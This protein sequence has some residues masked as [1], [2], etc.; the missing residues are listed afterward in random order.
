MN[1][2]EA[3]RWLVPRVA[4]ALAAGLAAV[5]GSFAAVGFTPRFVVAPVSK[6]L[7]VLAP[8]AAVTFAITVLGE[9]GNYLVLASAVALTVVLLGT[10]SV[11]GV[12]LARR[13][14]TPRLAPLFAG[15]APAVVAAPVSGSLLS[16]AAAGVGAGVVVAVA[17]LVPDEEP[18]FAGRRQV[19]AGGAAAVGVGLLGAAFGRGSGVGLPGAATPTGAPDS[20]QTALLSAA[21]DRTLE[22]GE[23]EPLVSDSFFNVDINQVNPTVD[24]ESWTL[25]VT[26]AVEEELDYD[27]EEVTEPA[28]EHRFVSLRCVG[29]DLNGKKLDTA[30]WSGVPLTDLVEPATP[31]GEYVMLRATDGFYEGFPASALSDALLAYEMNGEPLPRAHGSPAR[32]LVPGHWGEVNVKWVTEVEFLDEQPEGYWEQRGWHG[33]GPVETVTKLYDDNVT[34]L[35]DGEVELAGHAY[36]GTR[37]IERVEVSTDGGDTWNEADLSDPLPGRRVGDGATPSSADGDADLDL[38]TPG[39]DDIDVATPTGT[40]EGPDV[41]NDAWRQWIY[42]YDAPEAAHEVVVRAV[43]GAGNVQPREESGSY[44]SGATGWVS[45]EVRP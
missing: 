41:A 25:S 30:L 5:A 38:S 14:R 15:L 35:D 34:H 33:T 29:E 13:A 28:A 19:L 16:G 9:L 3:L 45:Q 6:L 40:T 44:P 27:Y 39:P 12:V 4:L 21:E 20:Q 8:G 2:R 1:G 43:D 31:E 42:R 24:H 36:A 37:G 32:V 7:T 23:L 10:G 22:S 17:G 18:T 26:G 11:A